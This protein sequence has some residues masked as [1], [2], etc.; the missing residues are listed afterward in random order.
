M[1][2]ASH[3]IRVLPVDVERDGAALLPRQQGVQRLLV[4]LLCRGEQRLLVL[5][6][7]GSGGVCGG[8][9]GEGPGFR[10]L[11]FGLFSRGPE[12]CAAGGPGAV[13]NTKLY[14]LTHQVQQKNA[15]QHKSG[16]GGEK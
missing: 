3:F 1:N 9:G 15:H 6:H 16:R 14:I 7:R 11:P 5:P 4:A 10:P 2:K 12:G 13:M 8:G